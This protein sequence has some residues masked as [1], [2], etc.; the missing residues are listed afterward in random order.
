MS[1]KNNGA[2][3]PIARST[4]ALIN[5]VD[6]NEGMSS[7]ATPLFEGHWLSSATNISLTNREARKLCL[8]SVRGTPVA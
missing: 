6:H 2:K 7:G 8:G 3:N 5:V 1:G 4:D